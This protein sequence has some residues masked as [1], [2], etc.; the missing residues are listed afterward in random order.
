MLLVGRWGRQR[1]FLPPRITQTRLPR[2]L[3]PFDP[4][5]L[6]G[7]QRAQSLWDRVE[8]TSPIPFCRRR[9]IYDMREDHCLDPSCIFSEGFASLPS[10]PL[11]RH[12]CTVAMGRAPRAAAMRA[13]PG[14]AER[15]AWTH[16]EPRAPLPAASQ[17]R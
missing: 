5:M 14:R 11:C 16:L 15:C 17:P 3:H 2:V 8:G 13:E 10:P 1:G 4:G 7:S 12:Y 9:V 6:M